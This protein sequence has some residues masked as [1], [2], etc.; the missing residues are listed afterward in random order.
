MMSMQS[1]PIAVTPVTVE[2][3]VIR[4]ADEG[5]PLRAIARCTK[6]PSDNLREV[7]QEAIDR[8]AILETPVEDWPAGT[9][10]GNRSPAAVAMT[11]LDDE[12][13]RLYLQLL[14]KTTP[15]ESAILAPFLRRPEVP[16]SHLEAI[17]AAD[18]ESGEVPDLKIIDVTI[19]KVRK[20]LKPHN[21]IIN[22]IFGR[23][24]E[25]PKADRQRAVELVLKHAKSREF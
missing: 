13:L 18:R 17:I 19:C 12:Q 21:L 24:Y 15:Q 8:G 23:G 10:R 22:V 25:M 9:N 7:F 2:Q 14:F 11:T 6:I 5:V 4:M 20:K 16:R 1:E 3:I